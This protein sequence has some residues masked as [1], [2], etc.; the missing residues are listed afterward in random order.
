MES[1][2]LVP[3]HPPCEKYVETDGVTRDLTDITGISA[4]H[5][6]SGVDVVVR[7]ADLQHSSTQTVTATIATPRRT[8]AVSRSVERSPGYGSSLSVVEPPPDLPPGECGY[9]F[10]GPPS[11]PC[12]GLRTRVDVR[13]ERV[14]FHVPR[15][16]LGDPA[17]VRAGAD[18][19]DLGVDVNY[20]DDWST[21][22][23][24]SGYPQPLGRRVRLG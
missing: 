4:R 20:Y 24:E 2:T 1:L 10:A 18:T 16:C 8:F 22:P 5:H 6:R 15:T 11:V 3:D 23:G 7:F 21:V 14:S 17:W 9:F 13:R 12:K 19:Y